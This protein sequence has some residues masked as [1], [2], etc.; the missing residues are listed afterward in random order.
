[1][2]MRTYAVY[3]YGLF[4]TDELMDDITATYNAALSEKECAFDS[5]ELADE[6]GLT[7]FGDVEG[8]FIPFDKTLDSTD[9]DSEVFYMLSLENEKSLF[10][11][12]YQNIEEVENEVIAKMQKY[13]PDGFDYKSRLGDI[14]GTSFG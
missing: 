4:I 9:L 7:R 12:A 8:E 3:D 1:M 10:S 14:R 6:I 2:S 11:R 5:D 13:V